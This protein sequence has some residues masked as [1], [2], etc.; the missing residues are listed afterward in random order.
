MRN[1]LVL[2]IMVACLSGC[3][4]FMSTLQGLFQSTPPHTP[5]EAMEVKRLKVNHTEL[6]YVE[7]GEGDTVV[8]V[9]GA[10]GDWRTWEGLRPFIA[11][12]YHYIALSRR[13]HYP[14]SWADE[15]QHYSLTQHVEDVA[16]FIRRLDVGKVHLV[17]GSYGGRVAGYVA[18]KYPELVRSVVMSDPDLI[19][20][21]TAQGVAALLDY[22]KDVA[23]SSAAAKA[24]DSW[25]ASMRLYD[26]VLDD[27]GAFQHAPVVQ[28]QR[29]LDNADTVPL[30]LAAKPPRPPSCEQLAALKVPALVMSGEKSRAVFKY[31]NKKLLDCLPKGT[32][33]AVV[34]DAPHLWY[35]VNPKAG[36]REILAFLAEH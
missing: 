33:T 32:E 28:Q 13:Y 25:E 18:L 30:M 21:T 6:S 3:Q 34:P 35:P 2:C 14:N 20:P 19:D 24:G 22:Q 9:H 29:W 4:D 23:K 36:A 26:A 12:K 31:S 5:T 10:S 11:Q 17:G 8:F 7:D 15:G 27:P 1:L 16:A